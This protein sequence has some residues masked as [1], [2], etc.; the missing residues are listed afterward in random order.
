MYDDNEVL[1]CQAQAGNREAL[2]QLWEAVRPL[3][4]GL[5]YSFY[6]HCGADVCARHGVT[7][8]DLR[9]ECYFAFLN[10]VRAY[11]PEKGYKLTTYLSHASKNRFRACM[12]IRGTHRNALDYAGSMNV[13]AAADSDTESGDLIPDEKAAAMLEAVDVRDEQ[14][15]YSAILEAACASLPFLQ[16]EILKRVY[17]DK[18]TRPQIAQAL[19]IAPEAVRREEAKA[20]R[21]L[22]GD[23]RILSL[24]ESG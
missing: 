22:R 17:R 13:P 2:A 20:L 16:R 4:Y 11:Q 10:A 23:C 19:H 1:A 14:R 15:F 12:G 8:E 5:A 24:K 7:L 3:L 9:Q 21:V 6:I 18:L